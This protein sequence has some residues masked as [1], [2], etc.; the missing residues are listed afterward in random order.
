MSAWG[1]M[2]K[3]SS[4][5]VLRREDMVMFWK[6][7]EDNPFKG[8]LD[9]ETEK[10]LSEIHSFGGFAPFLPADILEYDGKVQV[11]LDE[12]ET[13]KVPVTLKQLEDERDSLKAE[14]EG[15]KKLVEELMKN[16][17]VDQREIEKILRK[18]EKLEGKIED[19]EDI[20]KRMTAAGIDTI[21]LEVEL[22]GYYVR[23]KFEIHLMMGTIEKRYR[24]K[25]L[26]AKMTA[27]VLVHELM[28]AFFDVRDPYLKHPHCRSIEEPIVEYGMLCFMEMFE[29]CYPGYAGILNTAKEMVEEKKY[30]LGVCD[31]GF[32]SYLFEDRASFGVDWVSLFCS[33]CTF[34]LM[35]APQV[36]D[37]GKMISAIR[38]PRRE[39]SCEGKLYEAL[40]PRRFFYFGGKSSWRNNGNQLY[41]NVSRTLS[42]DPRFVFE[43]PETAKVNMKFFDKTGVQR[44]EGEMT[45][46][47][48]IHF[49]CG[50]TNPLLGQF[51]G[52]FG[53]YNKAGKIVRK[54][55]FA[56]YEE[57]P[58]DGI[59]PA[60]WVAIEMP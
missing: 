6:R 36:Q 49:F 50:N 48:R 21:E 4:G 38:Y 43:Y 31:Y 30:S 34:L 52:A 12:E 8:V 23:E 42:N 20:I 25:G 16:P 5:E 22:L 14:V 35:N 15:L 55:P 28:H 10:I 29:R 60:E 1:D 58:S 3:R 51:A 33:T 17:N 39:R 18:I 24:S 13:R 41:F 19:I 9:S 2:M 47:T 40:K 54:G 45:L 59:L 32:G 11:F 56:F 46:G 53:R 44:C 27:I 57:K 26:V 7:G 37:Y